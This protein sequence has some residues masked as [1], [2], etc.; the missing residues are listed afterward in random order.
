MKRIVRDSK[1]RKFINSLPCCSC[2]NNPPSQCSHIR[3]QH[4]G[5]TGLKP[6][7]FLTVPQCAKCHEKVDFIITS[8]NCTE[9]KTLANSLYA[10]SG[11]WKEAVKLVLE[12][13]RR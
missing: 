12:F 3:R 1:H 10:I 6:S 4:D 13:R 8:D 5:G 7:D 11:N 9:F 2:F